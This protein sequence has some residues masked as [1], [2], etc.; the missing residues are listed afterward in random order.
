[1]TLVP[2]RDELVEPVSSVSLNSLPGD[3]TVFPF[4]LRNVPRG[5]YELTGSFMDPTSP[6]NQWRYYWGRTSIKVGDENLTGI[7]L[8]L[9]PGTEMHGQ[10]SFHDE[11]T[12][13]QTSN[14]PNVVWFHL[15][16][17][18]SPISA[19]FVGSLENDGTFTLS[20]LVPGRYRLDMIRSVLPFAGDSIYLEDIRQ[21]GQSVYRN[22]IVTIDRSIV[23]VELVF[24]A[25]GGTLRGTVSSSKESLQLG[26]VVAL[27]PDLSHR[28]NSAL[29]KF[30]SSE[31]DGSFTFNGVAPGNYKVFS[32]DAIRQSA[33]MNSEFMTRYEDSGVPAVSVSGTVSQ[34]SHVPLLHV[35][36]K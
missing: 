9:E 24:N 28:G 16:N 32:F 14:G 21:D 22:G 23:N 19:D 18:H 2:V 30:T 13:I 4:E 15:L 6:N 31:P 25:N 33:V 8:T 11:K 20:G 5:T 35:I 1:V 10:V 27:V 3:D 17:N 26:V 29:Y 7:T 36:G 12:K 34:V